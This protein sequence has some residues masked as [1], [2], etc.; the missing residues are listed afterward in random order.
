MRLTRALDWVFHVAGMVS[1]LFLA[2]IALLTFVQIVGRMMGYLISTGTELA[3][4]C[5]A[6]SIF[7]ALAWTLRSGGHIRVTL[8]LQRLPSQAR[9]GV[10]IWCLGVAALAIGFFAYA[11]VG[12]AWESYRFDDVSV[13]IIV[14][15]LWIPQMAMAIGVFLMEIAVLE[16]LIRVLVGQDPAY[17]ALDTDRGPVESDIE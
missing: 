6:A 2:A 4:F 16:Q 12:M 11:A 13:G 17:G 5:M 8:F 3:G 10:E 14:V 9:R 7:L 1:A 15:P